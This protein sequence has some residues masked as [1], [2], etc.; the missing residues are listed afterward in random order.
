MGLVHDGISLLFLWF[1][2]SIKRE[3]IILVLSDY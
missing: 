2:D 3:S 1:I